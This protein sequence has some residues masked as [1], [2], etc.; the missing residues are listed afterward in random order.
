[1]KVNK[2][3]KDKNNNYLITLING[4]QYQFYD[5][6]IIKYQIFQ[7]KNL[8]ESELKD[9][10]KENNEL[11]VYYNALKIL[12]KKLKAESELR[13][14]FLIKKYPK[15]TIENTIKRLKKEGYLNNKVFIQSYINDKFKFNNYGPLRL[16]KDLITLGFKENEITP[17]L[18]LDYNEKI[19]QLIA[20]K[21]KLN[22]KLNCNLLKLNIINYLTNLGYRQ[23]MFNEFLIDITFDDSKLIQ[24][25]YQK[26][27][28]K[29]YNKYDNILLKKVIKN[30]LYQK[31][32]SLESINEVINDDLL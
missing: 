28:Y 18:N 9:I 16:K 14:I 11:E 10:L 20:K 31:G 32:Y 7:N 2:I 5:D 30:K 27:Y 4:N 12:S 24:K 6:I 22:N 19:K 21:I 13:K 25:D 3:E 8:L 1:M 15:P 26:L 29:F 17:Y 23:D